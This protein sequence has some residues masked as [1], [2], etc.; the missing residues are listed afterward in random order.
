MPTGAGQLR[1]LREAQQWVATKSCKAHVPLKKA[2][3]LPPSAAASRD[4]R[5]SVAGFLREARK[6]DF[7]WSLPDFKCWQPIQT[8]RAKLNTS[9]QGCVVC[10]QMRAE[11]AG[12]GLALPLCSPQCQLL[13]IVQLLRFFLWYSSRNKTSQINLGIH[14]LL[15]LVKYEKSY[16]FCC[17]ETCLDEKETNCLLSLRMMCIKHWALRKCHQLSICHTESM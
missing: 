11:W 15:L 2:A 9:A 10:S 4:Y 17:Q 8:F 16:K 1:R 6:L 12:R 13:G 7:M 3:L 14:Y 5:P